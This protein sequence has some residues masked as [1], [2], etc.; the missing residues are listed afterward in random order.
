MLGRE[1]YKAMFNRNKMSLMLLLIAIDVS[2]GQLLQR[3]KSMHGRRV[4]S[5]VSMFAVTAISFHHLA[6]FAALFNLGEQLYIENQDVLSTGWGDM[7]LILARLYVCAG[8]VF[9]SLLASL[10]AAVEFTGIILE[11]LYV[12]YEFALHDV[13]CILLV[14]KKYV[15]NTCLEFHEVVN[16]PW[17]IIYWT[18]CLMFLLPALVTIFWALLF[19]KLLTKQTYEVFTTLTQLLCSLS[20]VITTHIIVAPGMFLKLGT[21]GRA[22]EIFTRYAG[23][24]PGS[25]LLCIVVCIMCVASSVFFTKVVL[26]RYFGV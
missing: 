13:L 8:L 21:T 2:V 18:L 16:N 10:A 3:M 5:N 22:W 25:A 4:G 20:L 6:V 14:I 9:F 7:R 24:N 12:L 26:W 19:D 23:D 1:V 17:L 15:V 11:L